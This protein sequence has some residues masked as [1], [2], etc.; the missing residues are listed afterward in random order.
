MEQE[1][2]I[3]KKDQP[4]ETVQRSPL[5]DGLDEFL[6]ADRVLVTS[7]LARCTKA[8]AAKSRPTLE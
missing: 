5:K 7:R 3:R 4:V 8:S 1:V 6:G 2:G